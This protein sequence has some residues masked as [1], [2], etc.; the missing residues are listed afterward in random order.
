MRS[1]RKERYYNWMFLLPSLLGVLAFFVIPFIYSFYYAL[2][3]NLGSRNFVGLQNFTDTLT[4]E[5]FI[6]ASQNT[7]VF[8]VISVPLGMAL[9]L[10][11]A[12]GLR[13]M[14]RGKAM[15]AVALLLP[16]VVPSGATVYFWQILFGAN[17]LFNRFAI[18]FGA[19]HATLLRDQWTMGFLIA[20]YLWKNISFN[21]ILFWSGL[22]WIPNTYYEQMKVDGIG[23]WH[24][25]CHITMVYLSPTTLVVLLISIVNSFKVFRE[26]QM[27]FGSYP[28]TDIY[29]L[30]HYLNNQF[31][32]MNMAKL[33]SAAYIIIIV[34]GLVLL[35][36]F[37]IQKRVTDMFY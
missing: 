4:N 22:N 26:I 14:Q 35:G 6:R 28:S 30:Q 25:F 15:V 17:G 36:V 24:R 3:D 27:L 29:M 8:I 37:Y 5:L 2:I 34:L 11:L 9:S 23:A 31:M 19:D 1:I 10:F 13:S 33:S 20:I 16:I 32:A 7:L 18:M 21:I 12:S